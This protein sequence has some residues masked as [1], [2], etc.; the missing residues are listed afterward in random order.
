MF[1]AALCKLHFFCCWLQTA[2]A[3]A[4]ATP[5]IT[6]FPDTPARL[7]ALAA[8]VSTIQTTT[9]MIAAA[10]DINNLAA[11]SQVAQV[12]VSR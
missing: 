8:L 7:E 3:V 12:C 1:A 5:G 4:T 11:I 10:T 9:T 6:T 2:N